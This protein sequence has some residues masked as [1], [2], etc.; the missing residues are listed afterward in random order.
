MPRT[1]TTDQV[2]ADPDTGHSLREMSVSVRVVR[3][4]TPDKSGHC[5]GLSGLSGAPNGL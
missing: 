3:A 5:P 4:F 2:I 1:L